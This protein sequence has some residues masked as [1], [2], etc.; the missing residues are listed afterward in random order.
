MFLAICAD[1]YNIA[2]Q[3]LQFKDLG[4]GGCTNLL[5]TYRCDDTID[6]MN[7]LHNPGNEYVLVQ[8]ICPDSCGKCDCFDDDDMADKI[9]AALGAPVTGGCKAALTMSPCDTQLR[10]IG[11]LEVSISLKNLRKILMV[12][13]DGI[14]HCSI[15]FFWC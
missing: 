6:S 11:D 1:Q 7:L 4:T 12:V 5:N 14:F 3:I 15:G 10:N 2:E 13:F 9:L 8:D